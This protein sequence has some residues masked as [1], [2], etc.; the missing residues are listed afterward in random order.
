MILLSEEGRLRVVTQSDHAHL[1]GEIASLWRADGLPGN[2]RREDILFAVREHDNGWREADSAPRVDPTT[3]RPHDFRTL[4]S[5]V[6]RELWL[7]GAARLAATRPGRP[8]RPYAALLVVHHALALHA[9]HRGEEAWDEELLAFL[10]ERY[11]ELLEAAEAT[12]AEVAADYRFL[13]VADAVSLLA[14][15]GPGGSAEGA[16]V[17]GHRITVSGDRV[18]VWPFPLAGATTFRVPARW[19]PDRRY[20]GDADLGGELATARWARFGV[21]IAP[22]PR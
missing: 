20:R 4:P 21:R 6:R 15:S 14:C 11:E 5:E 17:A 1:A 12:A 22:G 9:D 13:A 19:I 16:E 7:R 2:P 18:E 8:E 10:D 3:G